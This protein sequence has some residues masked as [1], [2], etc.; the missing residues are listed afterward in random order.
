M[1]GQTNGIV[2]V[3]NG[4]SPNVML[5]GGAGT[6]TLVG[7]ADPIDDMCSSAQRVQVR[8]GGRTIGDL[9]TA[10]GVTWGWFE[11]GFDVTAKNPN[12]TTGCARSHRSAVTMAASNDYVTHHE[13]FNATRRPANRTH[14]RPSSVAADGIR[15]TR[16]IINAI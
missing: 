5:D 8:M 3:K 7:D 2:A 12:G 14:A 15:V 6:F 11:A 10:A 4:T 16:R 9:L 1:S 13:P